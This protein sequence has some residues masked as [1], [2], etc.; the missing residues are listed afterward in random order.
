LKNGFTHTTQA[1]N[2]PYGGATCIDSALTNNRPTARVFAY[3]NGTPEGGGGYYLNVP[4]GVYYRQ[5]WNRWCIYTEDT[6]ITIPVG[7]VFNVFVDN[8]QLFLS[9]VTR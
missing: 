4:I 2:Q 1:A 5:N 9:L 8:N 7:T 3:V 6:D